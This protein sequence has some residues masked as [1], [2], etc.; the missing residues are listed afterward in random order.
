[1]LQKVFVRLWLIGV[2][3][4][5]MVAAAQPEEFGGLEELLT[6]VVAGGG[7]MVLAGYVIAYFLENLT[8]WHNLPRVVKILFP[9]VLA[10]VF[11]VVAQSVLA[12]EL[13]PGIPAVFQAV[14]L[15]LINWLFS[16]R[17]YAGIKSG[18]YAISATPK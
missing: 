12:L 18:A 14:L 5:L 6:W 3:S 10:G 13:L 9:I 11:G 15:M 7:A 2:V 17:A 1:M 8:F 4:L 16:Q